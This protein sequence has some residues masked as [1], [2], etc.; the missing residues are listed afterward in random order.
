MNARNQLN[1]RGFIQCAG[2]G[3]TAAAAPLVL[4]SR[5]CAASPAAP[6]N[7]LNVALTGCGGRGNDI[8]REA[9]GNGANI[10]ALCDPDASRIANTRKTLAEKTP[11]AEKARGYED[12]RQLIDKEKSLDAVLIAIGP[13]WHAPMSTAFIKAGKH[14]YCEKPL[15][16]LVSEARALGKLAQESKVA[17]QMGT[18]GA[19]S[20]SFRRAVEIVQSGLLGQIREVHAWNIAHPR[21]P[22]SQD[23]PP[24]EDAVPAGF[25]WDLW[26]GPAPVRPFKRD[27]Y[28]P[29]CMRTFV[30]FDFGAGLIAEFGTHTWQLPI[31]ALKLDYP[32]RVEH[33]VPEPV[34]ETYASNAK[35]RYEFAARGHLAPVTGWYYDTINRPP[36]EA[37]ADLK[38]TYGNLPVVGAM[39]LGD[40]GTMYAGG[41]GAG[42]LI[43]LKGE[44][45]MRGV[46]DHPAA[47][48]IPRTEPRQAKQ[49]HMLE[50]LAAA[51]G[52]PKPY[53]SFEVS[54]HA[55]EVTLPAIVSLRMQRPIEWDGVNMQVPGA[56]EADKFIRADYR[57]KWLT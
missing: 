12:Y 30:W 19:A 29:G 2:A 5:L 34:K 4:P 27:T 55:M 14:V 10:I 45:K 56:P 35:I 31:R 52:G 16:R 13:W 43:K 44:D 26:L 54:A 53:Q 23:R 33:N 1:R 38:A 3:L 57:K 17:T 37:T 22:D 8:V 18:Q 7:R 46:S 6:S 51:K 15:T 49:N 24:G 48:D 36:Q 28:L 47:K 42:N 9:I 32:V 50:W 39:L 41:W 20:E 25:N 21:R 40:K 11:G